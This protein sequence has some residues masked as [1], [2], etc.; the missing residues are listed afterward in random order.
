MAADPVFCTGCEGCP[1]GDRHETCQCP[2]KSE[3]TCDLETCRP[4]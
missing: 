1:E 3:C 2:R 4:S